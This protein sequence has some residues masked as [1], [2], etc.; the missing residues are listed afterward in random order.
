MPGLTFDNVVVGGFALCRVLASGV[1]EMG[2]VVDG[3]A[4]SLSAALGS[5]VGSAEVLFPEWDVHLDRLQTWS[6]A[7][8]SGRAE[9]I[10]CPPGSRCCPR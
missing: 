5:D 1:A 7:V 9:R 3:V 2:V 6:D 4:Y 8:R 10:P